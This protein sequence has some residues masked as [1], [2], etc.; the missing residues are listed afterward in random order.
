MTTILLARHG[1]VQGIED[2]ARFR[3]RYNL[4][5]SEEGISQARLLAN[6]LARQ[7]SPA[8]IYTSPMQRCIDTG[9]AIA[10]ACR[11]P[12]S[13]LDGLADLDY[14]LWQWKTYVEV[15][16]EYPDLFATWFAA[17]QLIRFPNGDSLQNL[18]ARTAEAVRM[19]RSRHPKE[20]VVLVGHES[21]NRTILMQM[22]DQPLSSYWR[23][24]QGPCCLN[25]IE[26][27]DDHICVKC[28]NDTAHIQNMQSPTSQ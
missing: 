27:S 21:V 6:R 17:P 23:L 10:D 15:K 13:V 11:T 20:T 26:F 12:S 16:I 18:V 1:H 4:S 28:V 22:L 8:A 5:L 2:S 25:H 7:W 19:V 24:E 14:G 9:K 3:G